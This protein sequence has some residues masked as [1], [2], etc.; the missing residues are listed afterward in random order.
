V[1]RLKKTDVVSSILCGWLLYMVVHKIT[2]LNIMITSSLFIL[3][4]QQYLSVDMV[5][6]IISMSSYMKKRSCCINNISACGLHSRSLLILC[7][8]N[9]MRVTNC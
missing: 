3:P 8:S 5:H 9:A 4:N 1:K 6:L 2:S 7:C